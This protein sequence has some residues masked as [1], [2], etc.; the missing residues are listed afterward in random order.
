MKTINNI[1]VICFDNEGETFDRY[2]VLYL[3]LIIHPDFP[4]HKMY[5][6]MSSN[7]FH[8]QGFAQHGEMQLTKMEINRLKN[9]K[10]ALPHWGKLIDFDALPIDC[11]RCVI[12]DLES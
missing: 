12:G 8:P 2:S 3:D 6:G 1:T 4:C 9:G 11:Q 10:N 5:I 7:P